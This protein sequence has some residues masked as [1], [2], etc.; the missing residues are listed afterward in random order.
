MRE[1]LIETGSEIWRGDP[2]PAWEGREPSCGTVRFA[3]KGWTGVTGG[4]ERRD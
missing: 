2:L 1:S 3:G 4:Q